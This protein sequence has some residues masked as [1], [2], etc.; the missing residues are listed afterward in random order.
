[1]SSSKHLCSWGRLVHI[2]AGQHIRD[3]SRGAIQPHNLVNNIPNLCAVVF[4]IVA[5]ALV[6]RK[7]SLKT[8]M[9]IGI[10]FHAIGGVMPAFT[11]DG[12]FAVLLLGRFVFGVG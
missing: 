3:L 4:T 9:L 5:G 7:V 10:G 2:C 8:M 1:M 11:G 6:N 12:S